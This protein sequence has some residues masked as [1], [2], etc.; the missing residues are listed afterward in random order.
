MGAPFP[1]Q[2][3]PKVVSRYVNGESM[4]RIATSY[5]VARNT[6]KKVLQRQGVEIRY[7]N[8]PI[9]ARPKGPDH[10]SWKGGRIKEKGYVRVWVDSFHPF[11]EMSVAL[12]GSHYILEHRLVMA[13]HLGR[14]LASSETVHHKN[15][16][17][18]DNRI[19]NLQL[20][21]GAHG[22]GQHWCC[23]DCGSV[24]IVAQEI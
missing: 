16:I 20:R 15:G 23:A 4:D 24:N 2:D 6:I 7:K 9:Y 22:P 12:G 14:L 5:G 17:E 19:E 8:D 10:H 3:Y 13:E 11:Y 21:F 1:H 18:D